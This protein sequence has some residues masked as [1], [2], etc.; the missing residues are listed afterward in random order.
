MGSAESRQVNEL[1]EAILCGREGKVTR[2]L[3]K[4]PKLAKCEFYGG[5]TNPMCRGTYL[6]HRNIVALLLKNGADVN[7][8][9]RDKRSP[10]IWASFRDNC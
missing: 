10:L 2:L 8:C 1:L 5:V 4:E 7:A 9:S 6:G 3:Q